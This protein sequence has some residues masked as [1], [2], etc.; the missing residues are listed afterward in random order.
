[1]RSL[2]LHARVTGRDPREVFDALA[3]FAGYADQVDRVHSV[4]IIGQGDDYVDTRWEVEFRK[5]T[6]RWDERE[7]LDPDNLRITF[8]QLDGDDLDELYG[9]WAIQV[10]DDACEVHFEITFDFGVPS[11]ASILEPI[12]ERVL[13]ENF[14]NVLRGLLGPDVELPDRDLRPVAQMVAGTGVG[15]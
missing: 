2:E 5:G 13:L 8:E 9:Q 10:V 11:L 7:H 4:E 14:E 3:D 12:A 15:A 6:L 1:M